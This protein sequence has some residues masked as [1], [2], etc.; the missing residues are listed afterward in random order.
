MRRKKIK[1]MQNVQ[2]KCNNRK[3]ELVAEKNVNYGAKLG[4]RQTEIVIIFL[5]IAIV[6]SNNLFSC[7]LRFSYGANDIVVAPLNWRLR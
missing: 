1:E 2:K 4:Q 5:Q 7:D 6:I 3:Y